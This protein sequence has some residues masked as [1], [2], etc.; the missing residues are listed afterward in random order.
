MLSCLFKQRK[1]GLICTAFLLLGISFAAVTRAERLPIKHLTI[2]DGLPQNGISKITQDASG[3]FWFCTG[4]GLARFD[5]YDF[6]NFTTGEGLPRDKVLDFLHAREGDYWLATTGGLVAFAPDGIAYNR[7]VT[8]DEAARL[9]EMPLFTT[10]FLP[11][12]KNKIPTNPTNLLQ[13]SHGRIWVGSSDGL[14]RLEKSDDQSKHQLIQ[15][16]L[17]PATAAEYVYSLYEDRRGAIWV[18]AQTALY[19]ILPDGR[20]TSYVES[21]PMPVFQAL[22]EDRRGNF[23]V[24]TAKKGLFQFAVDENETPKLIRHFAP[25]KYADIEWIDSIIESYD[26]K[27]WLGT[28]DGL[29][30]FDAE[31]EKLYFYTQQSGI[32]YG[33]YPTI[34]EDKSGSLWLGTRT[35]GAFR[36]AR[37]GLS[38]FG[39]EDKIANIRSVSAMNDGSLFL[40]GF[41]FRAEADE[42]GAKVEIQTPQKG[43]KP[44]D[45][46]IGRFDGKNFTWLR[47]ALPP[48]VTYFGWNENQLNFQARNGEWWI[49]TGEGLFRYPKTDFEK[50][51]TTQPI[52][53]FDKTKGL[54][55][56]DVFRLYEDSRGDVWIS[57]SAV[58]DNGFFVWR[59]DGEILRDAWQTEGLSSEKDDLVSSFAEDE[60]GNLWIG[61]FYGGVA[62]LS[63]STGKAQVFGEPEGI[64]KGGINHI[65]VDRTGDVWLVSARDGLAR[66]DDAE[67]IHPNFVKFTTA[68]G[69]SSNRTFAVTEDGQGLIYVATD[70]DV[71]RLNPATGEVKILKLSDEMPTREFRTAMRD[72]HGTLWFGTT[73]GLV[74]YEPFADE[75]SK[76]PEILLTKIEIEGKAQKVS[77]IGAT[78]INLPTLAPEQNQVR[79]DFVSLAALDDE[80]VRYQYKFDSQTDWSPPSKERFV[81]FA[82]LSSGDYKIEFRAVAGDN[83]ASE[84]PA[85]VTF[86]ILPPFYL[87][88]WFLA[89]AA[90]IFAAAI[91]GFYR[92]RLNNLLGIERTRTRIATDLHDD[93]GANLSKI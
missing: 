90:L 93:I 89:A 9:P 82:N 36:L 3:F 35:A 10:Y 16:N 25:E 47:P 76:P 7:V 75:A 20:I 72:A 22:L 54:A 80:D 70:R 73:E 68:N 56:H 24:G 48:K 62:R 17:P 50:L 71:N 64:P 53:V 77:A 59:R 79:I 61:F 1:S 37:R 60:N 55:P 14:F 63:I 6:T 44:Y 34:F 39:A 28:L 65:Y 57:T 41:I 69:L 21:E 12:G 51:A 13:D 42:T 26:G 74:K 58:K 92:Y 49:A 8:F 23:W 30:E 33:R 85:A 4:G 29:F 5:G 52:S 45:W 83:L 18:A 46:K 67:S 40:M 86:K 84:Q 91:Y 81:N 87:R 11:D 15:I 27:L 31:T 43:F 66:I 32:V 78:E 38:A 88:A 19:R 2:A